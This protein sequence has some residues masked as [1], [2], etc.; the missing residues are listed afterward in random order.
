[1]LNLPEPLRAMASYSQFILWEARWDAVK[2]KYQKIPINP[3]TL[4]PFPKGDDWQET[5]SYWTSF[6]HAQQVCA[7]SPQHKVGFIFTERD[8]FFF[9]DIDNA[10]L[11][12][13]KT[14]SPLALDLTTAFQ[15][16][17]VEISQ[18]GKGLHIFG[19]GQAPVGHRSRDDKI[20]LEFYTSGRFVALTGTNAIGDSGFQCDT[21]INF[22]LTKYLPPRAVQGAQDWTTEPDPEWNGPLDD[23]ELIKKM[24]RAKSSAAA[25]FNNRATLKMLWEGDE[26]ELGKFYPSSTG[27]AFDRSAADAALCQHLAFWTG[28]DCDRIQRLFERSGLMRDK[29]NREDYRHDTVTKGC[30][31]C[32]SVYKSP[33]KPKEVAEYEM[34]DTEIPE[35]VIREGYQYLGPLQQIDYFKDCV[36][37]AREHAIKLPNGMLMKSEQFRARYGGYWFAMD[38]IGDKSTKSA[39]EVFTESQALRFPRA[40]MTCFRPELPPHTIIVED[41][42]S[43]VNTYVP[44]VTPRIEGDPEPFLNHLRKL[45]PIERDQRILLGYMAACVQMIGVKFRWAPF[46][47]GVPGNGKSTLSEVVA[48]AI[49]MRYSHS[50]AAADIA[51]KFNDWMECKIFIYVE[52]VY[53]ADRAEVME[54]LKPLITQR[55]VE[56]QPKGSAKYMADNRANFMLNSN[57]K[58]GIRKTIDDRRIAPFYTMQQ[59]RDDL[60]RDGMGDAYFQRL[61]NWL[62]NEDGYAIVANFLDRYEIADEFNPTKMSCAPLTGSTGEAIAAGL[63]SVEQDVLEAIAQGIPGFMNGWISSIALDRLMSTRKGKGT[64]PNNKRKDMLAT[65]GYIPH[66]NLPDGRTTSMVAIDGMS[67]PRLYIKRDH[68]AGHLTTNQQIV[69]AYTQAQE[70]GGNFSE[71]SV[72][73]QLFKKTN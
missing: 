69:D 16:C 73:A 51:N 60:V 53:T 9:V 48:R 15:G 57:H 54:T 6:S 32:A 36:Y 46:I 8:P 47:Q 72:T 31:W 28:K 30:A 41:G 22:L 55:W 14:W 3:H 12:D 49:G 34:G 10:L 21:G 64:V 50:P 56:V 13:G 38:S 71:T 63:G 39:W 23:D 4:Q 5:P 35:G 17:A 68:L 70:V 62:E 19:V 58:D 20:G 42:F 65:L 24:L 40:D 59:S 45:L 44:L 33:K 66:P 61:N 2:N 27:D 43:R 52:D 26:E 67:K 1:M 7:L 25:A 29:F 37:V 11:P 18:S